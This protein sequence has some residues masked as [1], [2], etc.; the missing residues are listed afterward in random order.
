M[1]YGVEPVK[2]RALGALKN[3]DNL[4][5][6]V[7]SH[8]DVLTKVGQYT[9]VPRQS[10]HATTRNAGLAQVQVGLSGNTGM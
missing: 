10:G 1:M 3:S 8:V 7:G 4:L 2:S 5:A 6:Y 9:K